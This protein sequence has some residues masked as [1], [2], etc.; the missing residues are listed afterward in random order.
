MSYLFI[1]T[2]ERLRIRL[3]HIPSRGAIRE[4]AIT[5][6]RRTVAVIASFIRAQSLPSLKGIVVVS[7]PGPFSAVRSGVL[8]AN[9]LARMYHI[10]LYG[11]SVHHARNLEELRSA[12][13]AKKI[14][15]SSYVAPVYDREPNITC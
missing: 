11:V 7:G 1:D 3:A 12:F 14:R 2:S 8:V 4:R 6:R 5:G 15:P 9:L 13:L 10:P